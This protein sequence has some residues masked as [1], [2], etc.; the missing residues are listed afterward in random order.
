MKYNKETFGVKEYLTQAEYWRLVNAIVNIQFVGSD[1]GET[2]Y[3]PEYATTAM[4][5]IIA[6]TMLNGV[7]FED[8]EN[9]MYDA[10]L[11]EQ[12]LA[13]DFLRNEIVGGIIY[14]G[15]RATCPA[16]Y[17]SAEEDARKIVEYR[18]EMMKPINVAIKKINAVL[19][20]AIQLFNTL[21]PEE[22]K[23]LAEA[24]VGA[25]SNPD[26]PP[27]EKEG[28]DGESQIDA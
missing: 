21:K 26:I 25:Q 18:L 28:E 17:F 22:I 1:D 20:D 3:H 2:V 27:A 14:G 9:I 12:I 4:P 24:F 19:G 11:V 23:A 8:D 15:A 7:E 13:D 6:H 16:Y 10:K 5:S